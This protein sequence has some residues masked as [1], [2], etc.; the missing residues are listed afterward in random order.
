MKAKPRPVVSAAVDPPRPRVG[1]VDAAGQ[2]VTAPEAVCVRYTCACGQHRCDVRVA[3]VTPQTAA[4]MQTF[5]EAMDR[6]H[7]G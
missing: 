6:M 2:A 4:A 7:I 5:F 3:D 1:Y